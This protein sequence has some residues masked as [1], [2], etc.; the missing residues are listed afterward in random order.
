[1]FGAEDAC[2]IMDLAMYMISR[3]TAEMR[4][5]PHWAAS[6][7][8]FSESIPDAGFISVFEKEISLSLISRFRN[9]WLRRRSGTAELSETDVFWRA[10]IP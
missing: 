9:T 2:L 4:H 3:E 7:A 6:H 10:M 1:M 5:F 8:I